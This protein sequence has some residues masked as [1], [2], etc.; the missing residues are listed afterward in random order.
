MTGCV[1]QGECMG[2]PLA[3]CDEQK[4]ECVCSPTSSNMTTRLVVH[5]A[6]IECLTGTYAG[7]FCPKTVI[8]L[9]VMHGISM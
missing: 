8:L 5:R 3:S 2:D 1:R 6:S 4:Q 9:F 7:L